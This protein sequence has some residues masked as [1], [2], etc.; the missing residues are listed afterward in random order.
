MSPPLGAPVSWRQDV[1]GL[2]ITRTGL[3]WEIAPEPL[4]LWVIP[5][6]LLPGEQCVKLLANY[7]ALAC[8][9]TPKTF[10]YVSTT[11]TPQRYRIL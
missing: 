9:P 8:A 3:V 7:I 2:T 5:D 11:H 10:Y 1:A 4:C 6:E